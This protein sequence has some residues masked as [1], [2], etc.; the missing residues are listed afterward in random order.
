MG[1]ASALV[2]L[3]SVAALIAVQFTD[4]LT[5]IGLAMVAPAVAFCLVH[6]VRKAPS[7]GLTG[8]S[9]ACGVGAL[10]L[11][12]AFYR[13]GELATLMQASMLFGAS[14]VFASVAAS[15]RQ[16][17]CETINQ[18]ESFFVALGRSLPLGIS[19]LV[20]LPLLFYRVLSNGRRER[21]VVGAF[22]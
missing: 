14:I 8:L 17:L 12:I 21:R 1:Y 22:S 18:P 7:V 6:L 10:V 3:Q 16:V 13:T 9:G 5:W 19:F 4:N 15:A 11:A 20:E 2:L